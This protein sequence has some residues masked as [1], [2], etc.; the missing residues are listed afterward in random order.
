MLQCLAL[1]ITLS[2]FGGCAVNPQQHADALAQTAGLHPEQVATP[3]FLLT[4]YVRITRADQPLSIYIEG[5]GYAW[6]NRYQVSTNPTPKRALG[7]TLAVADGSA[8]VV[9]L[10]RPCQFTAM[11]ANPRCE[12]AYW[13]GKRFAPE[14]IAALDTAISHYASRTPGQ[15]IHLTGYSGGAAV[16][17]LVAAQRQ[18]IAT[19]RTVAGNLD[20][21]TV[22]RWHQVSL[23]PESLN[24][25]NV[26]AQVAHIPQIH[27]SGADD[28]I[29]PLSVAQLFASRVGACAHVQVVD[30]LSHEGDWATYWPQL[31]RLRLPCT[32]RPSP[33][34]D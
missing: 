22:N 9:Y 24:P 21:D 30:E 20:H 6:R 27:F 10:A 34:E 31:L 32:T 14:A 5:D 2:S 33:S 13:T 18:D 19:L 8:N 28:K 25:I 15:R 23:M 29:V 17:V 7:L 26:T 4:A 1:A 16:A 11:V 12:P 3:V